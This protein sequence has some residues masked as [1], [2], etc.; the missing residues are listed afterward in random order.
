MVMIKNMFYLTTKNC[1]YPLFTTF[2]FFF[3]YKNTIN[4]VFSSLLCPT[5]S[6]QKSQT[7]LFQTAPQTQSTRRMLDADQEE[8]LRFI[9]RFT[10]VFINSPI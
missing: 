6:T 4:K 1:K 9:R 3:F 8:K 10:S 7:V 2:F 5:K